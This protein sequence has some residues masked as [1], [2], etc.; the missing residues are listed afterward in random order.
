MSL[1]GNQRRRHQHHHDPAAQPREEPPEL[2]SST[3]SQRLHS[4][5]HLQRG[6][7]H[8]QLR[9]RRHG[10]FVCCSCA[11][12]L[13]LLAIRY[14]QK[15]GKV[16][17]FGSKEDTKG[18]K[19]NYKHGV[20]D[21]FQIAKDPIDRKYPKIVCVV[22]SHSGHHGTKI[23][24]IQETWGPKCD[25]L[26]VAS[27]QTD[28]CH[29]A[30]NVLE[31]STILE[32]MRHTNGDLR[33]LDDSYSN[34]WFK[35]QA[36]ME[37]LWK[38]F[39]NKPE[40][41]W[42]FKIDDDTYVLPENLREFLSSSPQVQQDQRVAGSRGGSPP[43]TPPLIYGRRFA[44][45]SFQEI[46]SSP[47]WRATMTANPNLL[48]RLRERLEQE[49]QQQQRSEANR[50]R[51]KTTHLIYNAGG[52]G[53]VM[54]RSYLQLLVKLL[55]D[56]DKAIIPSNPPP[57]EDMALALLMYTEFGT[58]SQDSR[59]DMGRQRFH[60]EL[61]HIMYQFQPPPAA[62]AASASAASAA[63]SRNSS[64]PPI[65]NFQQDRWNYLYQFQEHVVGSGGSGGGGIQGGPNCCSPYSISFHHVKEKH[66]YYLHRQ[67]YNNEENPIQNASRSSNSNS[68]RGK[69]HANPELRR[70]QTRKGSEIG[71]PNDRNCGASKG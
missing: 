31:N 30:V 69:T 63:V 45:P 56:T 48:R 22:V 43:K 26:L 59:D 3:S 20:M 65:R 66:M 35:V 21:L 58:V 2:S 67:F 39:E 6:C 49:Q 62:I 28:P 34:L 37:Y 5:K 53:Y 10:V 55:L 18:E 29:G 42:F 46:E 70:R 4:R 23:K 50:S 24:A 16:P 40:Y 9:G 17:I 13:L 8:R 54:N 57:P 11:I 7:Y 51:S 44:W 47:E 1:Y 27:N 19:G 14:T 52:A 68:S 25:L 60:P 12:A 38:E 15:S 61:P 36:T 41:E 33:L 32:R 64:R 71:I